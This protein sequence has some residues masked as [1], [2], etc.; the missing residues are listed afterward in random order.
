M[1]LDCKAIAL[2]IA[3]AAAV[4]FFMRVL[5]FFAF[6]GKRR[7]PEWLTRLGQA[8]PPAIMAVLIVYCTKDALSDI[9]AASIPTFA[10]VLCTAVIHKLWHNT[11]LTIAGGTAVYML[12]LR[13]L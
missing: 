5:P 8:L 13:L 12:L 6:S 7:M 11:L 10:G 9:G 3:A 4:T 1:S 2:T